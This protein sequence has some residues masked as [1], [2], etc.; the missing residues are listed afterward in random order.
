MLVAH[1]KANTVGI[2]QF[3][4]NID[5]VERKRV[6]AENLTLEK[7]VEIATTLENLEANLKG[8]HVPTERT[9]EEVTAT[10]KLVTETRGRGKMED[11]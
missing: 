9:E 7:A 4:A 6:T 2:Q 10:T 3:V 11:K 8:L 5:D 1:V